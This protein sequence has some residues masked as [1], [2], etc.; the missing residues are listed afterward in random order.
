[1]GTQMKGDFKAA[2]T[3]GKTQAAKSC[4]LSPRVLCT[5]SGGPL[6]GLLSL[7]NCSVLICSLRVEACESS[8]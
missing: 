1:M 8:L 6:R 5:A 2:L 4:K 3:S 7:H